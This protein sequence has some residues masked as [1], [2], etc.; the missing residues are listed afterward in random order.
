MNSTPHDT[1]SQLSGVVAIA[2]TDGQIKLVAKY[3]GIN[4]GLEFP[5]AQALQ[6]LKKRLVPL[7]ILGFTILS[8]LLPNWVVRLVRPLHLPNK[9]CLISQQLND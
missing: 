7:V 5:F 6:F 1:T 8:A 9:P 4:F 2:W 3:A